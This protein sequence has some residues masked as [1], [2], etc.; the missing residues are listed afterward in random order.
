V[1]GP[2]GPEAMPR[3]RSGAGHDRTLG[4]ATMAGTGCSAAR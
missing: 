3:L 1:A 4:P 2:N